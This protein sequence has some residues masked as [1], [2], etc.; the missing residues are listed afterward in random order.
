MKII[1][2]G[3]SL[4]RGISFVKG[5]LRILKDN[6]PNTLAKLAEP[7]SSVEIL[8]KGVFNDNSDLLVDRIDKD[9]ISEQPDIV[10]ISVGG[11][12][13]N[14]KWDEVAEHPTGTHEP[15]VPLERYL[16]NVTSMVKEFQEK[17]I[18]PFLITLPPLDPARYYSFIA[19][20]FGPSIG[21]WVSSVGGIEH[22]HGMYNRKLKKLAKELNVALIDVR[23]YIK[24]S[25]DLEE[26]IS[27]DGIHLTSEGYR[28]MSQAIFKD[29]N[30]FLNGK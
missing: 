3:D 30:T 25:G 8:N 12:D 9:I 7:F 2:F 20:K 14:F 4:T 13:C 27:D 24:S 1:C 6:Y 5:R 23:T 28:C 22:W 10:L 19:D 11:N 16:Q 21:H 18:T 29:L 26:L 17:H 15:I